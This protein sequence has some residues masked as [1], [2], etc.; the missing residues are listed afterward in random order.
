MYDRLT[1]QHEQLELTAQKSADCTRISSACMSHFVHNM[2]HVSSTA[3][4]A[5]ENADTIAQKGVLACTWLCTASIV[6][7]QRVVQ[8]AIAILR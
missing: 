6:H 1:L 5:H 3:P 4:Y 2:L 8:S 7:R